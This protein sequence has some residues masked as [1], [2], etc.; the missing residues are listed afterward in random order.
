MRYG[1][2]YIVGLIMIRVYGVGLTQL[3]KM[4]R[5]KVVPDVHCVL[6]LSE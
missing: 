4:E 3:V 6:V 5:N 1:Y 2:T